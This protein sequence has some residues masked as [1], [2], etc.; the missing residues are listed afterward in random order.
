MQI[1]GLIDK[2][3]Y[4]VIFLISPKMY[5][6]LLKCWMFFFLSANL[7]CWISSK[8]YDCLPNKILTTAGHI[9][10]KLCTDFVRYEIMRVSLTDSFTHSLTHS[11]TENVTFSCFGVQ[12]GRALRFCCLEFDKEVISDSFMAYSRIFREG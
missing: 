1:D 3:L 9:M 12:F 7:I 11:L 10:E 8:M 4:E 2:Y 5:Q 6:F